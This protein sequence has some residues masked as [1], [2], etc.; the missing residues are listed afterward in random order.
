MPM[1]KAILQGKLGQ[2]PDLKYTASGNAC[3][4]LSVATPEKWTDKNS[5]QKQEK[6]EW[7]R[8]VVYGKVAENCNQFLKSGSDVLVEGKIQTRSWDDP[9]GGGKR[10]ITEIVSN[11]VQF[12][13][14]SNKGQNGQKQ[15]APQQ[16][17]TYQKQPPQPPQSQQPPQSPQYTSQQYTPDSIPF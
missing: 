1:N 6:V 2:D 14:Y 3:V 12:I 15:A 9:Q 4:T 11:N 7:H 8:V 17:T 13:G 10:Y 5:G 16:G